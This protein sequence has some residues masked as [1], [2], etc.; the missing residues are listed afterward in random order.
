MRTLPLL[1]AALLLCTG[2]HPQRYT[3]IP[4]PGPA[5]R[6]SVTVDSRYTRDVTL[7]AVNGGIRTRLGVVT[8]GERR[9]FLVPHYL[10][11]SNGLLHL[12]GRAA[13]IRETLDLDPVKVHPGERVL[14][15]LESGLDRSSLGVW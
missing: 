14:L 5:T 8:A 1:G 3:P 13:E 12:M 2:C 15:T 7:Y 4:T 9:T 10:L 11:D 6:Y